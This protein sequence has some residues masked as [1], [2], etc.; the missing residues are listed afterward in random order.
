MTL[1]KQKQDGSSSGNGCR[2]WRDGLRF[3]KNSSM[4]L[5]VPEGYVITSIALQGAATF[6]ETG[7]TNSLSSKASWTGAALLSNL[8]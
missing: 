3:Y 7:T 6:R 4:T 5:A 2:L 8:T 1:F